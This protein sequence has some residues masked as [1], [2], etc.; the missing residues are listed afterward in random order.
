MC[1]LAKN[2]QVIIIYLNI[3]HISYIF[4]K[5]TRKNI[6]ID[7]QNVKLLMYKMKF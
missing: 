2:F 6:K 5:T 4:K 3:V 7:T 1:S